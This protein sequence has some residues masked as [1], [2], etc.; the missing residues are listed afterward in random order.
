LIASPSFLRV[1]IDPITCCV[2]SSPSRKS[3]IL[4]LDGTIYSYFG[5]TVLIVLV[6]RHQRYQRFFWLSFLFSTTLI[7]YYLVS[8]PTSVV[9]NTVF[10]LFVSQDGEEGAVS[11]TVTRFSKNFPLTHLHFRY[12]V[13]SLPFDKNTP[14]HSCSQ[15]TDWQKGREPFN[16]RFKVYYRISSHFHFML[17]E[18]FDKRFY[19]RVIILEG[20]SRLS[21]LPILLS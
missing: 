1:I 18:I 5:Q 12:D 6:Q 20:M 8:W 7:N 21:T 19:S 9:G 10:E 17:S 14:D 2:L 15:E 3:R 16:Q 4:F 13:S 11:Q